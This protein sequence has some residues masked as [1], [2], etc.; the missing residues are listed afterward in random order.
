MTIPFHPSL[1]QE[2]F[3]Y[4]IHSPRAKKRRTMDLLDE[5]KYWRTRGI[6]LAYPEA[7]NIRRACPEGIARPHVSDSCAH[8]V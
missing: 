6:R 8:A 3:D 4:G 5:V 7:H 2:S 1:S